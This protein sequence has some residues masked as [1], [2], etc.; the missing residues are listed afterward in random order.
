M[1][2]LLRTERG[3]FASID[4]L[5][6]F[7]KYCRFNPLTG[8]VEWIGAT[9]SAQGKFAKYGYFWDGKR[10]VLAH[11]WSAQHIH[12]L[13]ISDPTT[14][15]DHCCFPDRPCNTLCV[16]HVQVVPAAVNRELQWIRVQVGLLECPPQYEPDANDVPFFTDPDWM[17]NARI[18]RTE[19]DQG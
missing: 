14:Q 10:M 9:T 18:D 12:G 1:S 5:Q 8:C 2:R 3:T 4:P 16:Q 11:R 6:R 7:L 19:P 15:V 13:D 17:K